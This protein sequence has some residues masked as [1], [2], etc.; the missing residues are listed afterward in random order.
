VS[1]Q[2]QRDCINTIHVVVTLGILCA[3]VLGA[4]YVMGLSSRVAVVGGGLIA[5]LV[6][7][8]VSRHA[9]PQPIPITDEER[10]GMRMKYRWLV[11]GAASAL[12]LR[13]GI[14][15][16]WAWSGGLIV[17]SVTC[18]VAVERAKRTRAQVRLRAESEE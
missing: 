1:V 17:V 15:L 9:L 8:A 11:W 16:P 2:R 10:V 3:A 5:Y 13:F 12:L 14:G 18:A 4:R 6:A 7:T